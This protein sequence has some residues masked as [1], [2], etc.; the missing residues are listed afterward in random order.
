MNKE[1]RTFV[2]GLIIIAFL[3]YPV[4]LNT[5]WFITN[6]DRFNW[7][8]AILQLIGLYIGISKINKTT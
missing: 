3:S 4:A 2:W 6:D 5:Q 1:T 8:L 7:V